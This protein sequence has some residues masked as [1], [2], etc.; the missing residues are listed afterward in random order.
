[1]ADDKKLGANIKRKLGASGIGREEKKFK[2]STFEASDYPKNK[3]DEAVTPTTPSAKKPATS[4]ML[5]MTLEERPDFKVEA[6]QVV[7][8]QR[9]LTREEHRQTLRSHFVDN[10][11][12]LKHHLY[13]L[14]LEQ[15]RLTA[16][17]AGAA[18][19]PRQEESPNIQMSDQQ[20]LV[21]DH[22][23]DI[24]LAVRAGAGTGKTQT[25]VTRAIKLVTLHEVDSG[26]ILMLTFTN[27]AA[28]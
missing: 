2:G 25:M 19:E 22:P 23:P 11:Y 6:S 17:C 15:E 16:S 18:A 12:L 10:E 8:D 27:K 1:M 20:R 26:K 7:P 14:K 21:A 13:Q 4:N 24:P 5:T 9:I 28:T 3:S